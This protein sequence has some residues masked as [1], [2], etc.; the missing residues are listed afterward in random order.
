MS[1]C[2]KCKKLILEPNTTY[3][4]NPL[5]VCRCATMTTPEDT[6]LD[7][8]T[9]WT[10]MDKYIDTDRLSDEAVDKISDSIEALIF[11]CTQNTETR[12]RIDELKILENSEI[13]NISIKKMRIRISG[14][15]AQ[16][17]NPTEEGEK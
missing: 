4:I 16:L 9:I 5:A 3:G 17:T 8:N 14:R 1:Q 7:I 15:I 12:A 6:E 2:S 13:A 10:V 11:L